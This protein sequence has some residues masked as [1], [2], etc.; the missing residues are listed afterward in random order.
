VPLSLPPA[1]HAVRRVHRPSDPAGQERKF[2]GLLYGS[3]HTE[4]LALPNEIE[5]F[6]D[7]QA[8]SVCGAGIIGQA[9]IDSRLREALNLA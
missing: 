2:A 6:P 4:L 8:S 5:I 7:Y 9:L 1:I 3:L